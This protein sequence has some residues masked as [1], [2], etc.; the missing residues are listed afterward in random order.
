MPSLRRV[1]LIVALSVVAAVTLAP[2]LYGQGARAT[3]AGTVRNPQGGP[4]PGVTV[5]VVNLDT[6]DERPAI[7]EADGTYVVGGL[8]P[9]RYQVRVAE[10]SFAPFQS[11]VLTLAAGQRQTVDIALRPAAAPA[12]PAAAPAAG[13]GARGT[14]AGTVR[15]P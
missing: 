15:N 6:Q 1:S 12:A 5:N 9:G 11:A 8:L 10:A 14:I 3:V 4:Q 2:R 13:Q 7:T